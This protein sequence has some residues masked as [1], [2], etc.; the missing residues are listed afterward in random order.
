MSLIE[1]VFITLLSFR[2]SLATKCVLLNNEP[3]MTRPTLIDLNSVEVNYY[4]FISILGKYNGICISV[5]DLSVKI[6]VPTETKDVNV[7]VFNMITKINEDKR[8][9]KHILCDCKCKFGSTTWNK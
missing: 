6:C 1:Q 4:S 9:A 8:L 5:D 3:C 7:K 2:R